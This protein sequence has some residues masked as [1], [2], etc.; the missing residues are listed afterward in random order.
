VAAADAASGYPHCWKGAAGCKHSVTPTW[1][2]E[3]FNGS[4]TATRTRDAS[5]TCEDAASGSKEEVVSGSYSVAMTLSPKDSKQLVRSD[6]LGQPRTPFALNLRFN[7]SSVTH[8]KIHTV[9]PD[10][11]APGGC[12]STMRDCNKTGTPLTKPDKLSIRTANK[13]VTQN[14]AG[15][16]IEDAFVKCAPESATVNT[17]LPVGGGMFGTFLGE[18]TGLFNFKHKTTVVVASRSDRPGEGEVT[19]EVRARLSYS[20][21]LRRCTYYAQSQK[22]CVTAPG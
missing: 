6:A 14:M 1:E 19:S 17:L 21:I 7:V 10:A 13:R 20:R 3:T 12:T 5:L 16:F 11:S 22:R 9:T 18:V 8:E 15:R 4:V 2:L